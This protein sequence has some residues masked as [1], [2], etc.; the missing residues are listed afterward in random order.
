MSKVEVNGNNSEPLYNYLKRQP[1]LRKSKIKNE[2][3]KVPSRQKE[4][5]PVRRYATTTK[6][7]D[8]A[9]DIKKIL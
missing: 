7:A 5:K 8:I 9:S 1:G 6:P 3:Y 2:F 4:G